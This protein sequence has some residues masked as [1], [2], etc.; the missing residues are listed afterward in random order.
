MWSA[1]LTVG[2]WAFFY[3]LII[4]YV[5]WVCLERMY[6]AD[7]DPEAW[8]LH[9]PSDERPPDREVPEPTVTFPFRSSLGRPA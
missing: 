5:R 2:G 3:L 8:V 7:T 4:F 9:S 1:I 6:F